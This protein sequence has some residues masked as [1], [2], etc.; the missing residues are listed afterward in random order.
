MPG[1]SESQIQI[2]DERF[3]ALATVSTKMGTVVSRDTTGTGAV[4]VFDGSSGTGQPVKCF[5]HVIVMPN[6]RVGLV[7]YESEWI[8]TA[9]YTGRGLADVS[10]QTNFASLTQITSGTYVDLPGSP[11]VVYRKM[12]DSTTMEFSAALSSF[13]SNANNG[14]QLGLRVANTDLTVN[15]D[16]DIRKFLMHRP[17]TTDVHYDWSGVQR[18]TG[19]PA[20]VYTITGRWYRYSG[21]GFVQVDTN[22]AF[23][24]RCRE[25]WT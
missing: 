18:A 25:V 4:V 10:S 20:G 13:G 24:V 16:I 3:N 15:S 12:R 8:V 21:T 17:G 23:W 9:C 22:D 19:H 2:I 6:D 11:G 1:Y 7:K 14:A 5:E